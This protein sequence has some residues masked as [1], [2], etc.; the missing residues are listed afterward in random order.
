MI[1]IEKHGIIYP[2]WRC[3]CP[4]CGCQFTFDDEDICIFSKNSLNEIHKVIQCPECS[5]H[6]DETEW[7]N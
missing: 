6:I 3:T 4:N 7:D 1:Q 5:H 2:F